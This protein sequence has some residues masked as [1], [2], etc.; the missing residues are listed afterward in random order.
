MKNKKMIIGTMLLLFAISGICNVINVS[1]EEVDLPSSSYYVQG[2][3]VDYR[4]K[5]EI[6]ISSSGT[7]NTYIMN[8]EQLNTL[9][10]SG[11][12]TWNYLMRWKDM[13][14]LEYVYTIPADGM[15]YVVIYNKNLISTRIVDIQ[16]DIDYYH[17]SYDLSDRYFLERL[18]WWLLI[19]FVPIGI[20]I[21]VAIVLVKKHKR[22][23][24]KEVAI[25]QERA[26]PKGMLYCNECGAVVSDRKK[27]CSNCGSNIILN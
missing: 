1:A 26:T 8:D 2:Y 20:T 11:G 3:D 25:V 6:S 5:L 4:D 23:A 17:E 27:F 18:F 12:L 21:I 13:T 10:D 15:Y 19:I 7:I 22:K 16:A 9:T 24:P 14:Y